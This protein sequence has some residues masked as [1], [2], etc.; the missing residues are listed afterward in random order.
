MTSKSQTANNKIRIASKT[1]YKTANDSKPNIVLIGFMGA[2]KTSI[3][4]ILARKLNLELLETDELIQEKAGMS[5][6]QIFETAG[7]ITFRELEIEA[8]KEISQKEHFV[9][10]SG[11]GVVLNS[12]NIE[13]LRQRAIIVYLYASEGEIV[14]RIKQDKNPRPLISEKNAE[15][16]VKELM[17]LR[18]PLYRHSADLIIN[19]SNKD[20]ELIAKNII[21]RLKK[22][23]NLDL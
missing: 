14:N 1:T 23:E 20:V 2:G 17:K 10:A 7:E 5:I 13:R 21:S 11:G 22:N 12:I 9:I 6:S 8:V 18:G 4:K 3:G 16:Y 19:T 15:T